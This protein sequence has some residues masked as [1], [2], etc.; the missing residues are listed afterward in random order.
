[1]TAVG[2]ARRFAGAAVTI[3][4]VIT[5][6]ACTKSSAPSTAPKVSE[7]TLP[8]ADATRLQHAL[9]SDNIDAVAA[10][11]APEVRATYLKHALRVLPG[12]AQLDIDAT[13]M[14]VAGDT[15]TVPATVQGGPDA[16]SWLLVLEKQN[17]EWLLIG[18]EK[19]P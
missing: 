11:L 10:V 1:M 3:S 18:T 8:P 9:A 16:G 4:L 13:K 2:R 15:A 12:G 5:T 17:G 6:A 14:R 19:Q 7:S